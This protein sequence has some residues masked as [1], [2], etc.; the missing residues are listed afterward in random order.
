MHICGRVHATMKANT[1]ILRNYQ[2]QGTIAP[3]GPDDAPSALQ[4]SPDDQHRLIIIDTM[5]AS[6]T[7]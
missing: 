1:T 4:R 7:K 5:R 6:T 2:G 3:Y